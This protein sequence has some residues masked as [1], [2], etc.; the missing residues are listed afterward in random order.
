MVWAGII[1]IVAMFAVF[2][3]AVEKFKFGEFE[4][5]SWWLLSFGIYIWGQGL[6]LAPFWILFGLGCIFWWTPSQALIGYIVFH[7]V[8]SLVEL[9]LIKQKSYVGLASLI[10]HDSEKVTDSQK[11]HLY[12]LG[13]ALVVI[14]G[15]ILLY[16]A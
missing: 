9:L 5:S 2:V 13:Q 16:T 14:V 15:I 12:S 8:R 10:S 6:V 1:L 3:H 4:D 11:L 7:I